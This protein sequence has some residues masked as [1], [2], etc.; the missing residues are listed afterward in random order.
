[1]SH[2]GLRHKNAGV[3]SFYDN[4]RRTF[5]DSGVIKERASDCLSLSSPEDRKGLEL[6]ETVDLE[7][8]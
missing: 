3:S 7:A 4:E 2:R 6:G 8:E 1:M 5:K